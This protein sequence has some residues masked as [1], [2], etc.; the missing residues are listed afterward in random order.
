MGKKL[1]D[2]KEHIKLL[3]QTAVA[4]LVDVSKCNTRLDLTDQKI[5]HLF[6]QEF[7]KPDFLVR[8]G[9]L[10]VELGLYPGRF[11]ARLD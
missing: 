4:R 11:R 10:L 9:F 3:I 5:D 1:E 6:E 8:L 7:E 2:Q